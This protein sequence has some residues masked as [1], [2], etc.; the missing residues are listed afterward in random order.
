MRLALGI[1]LA[2]VIFVASG[3]HAQPQG[4]AFSY[5]GRLMLDGVAVDGA[6]NLEFRLYDAASG[7]SQIGGSELRPDWPIDG[8]L[9]STELDFGA[10]AFQGMARW[11]EIRVNGHV[12]EP[13]QQVQAAPYALFALD[14]NAGPEG[15]P[16][17]PGATG[18][19]GPPGPPGPAGPTGPEGPPGSGD[20]SG[21]PGRLVLFTHPQTGGDAPIHV[22]AGELVAEAN[23]VLDDHSRLKAAPGHAL[24]LQ[25]GAD[26]A[27]RIEPG[28][29]GADPNLIAGPGHTM[30]SDTFGATA[31]GGNHNAPTGPYSLI[32]G[33]EYNQASM[34]LATVVGGVSNSSSG[35]ISLVAG[36]IGGEAFGD[37]TA[38]IGGQGNRASGDDAG[39]LGGDHN[40]A[41]GEFSAIVGGEGNQAE[42]SVSGTF[43]ARN[44]WVRGSS[45]AV[46]GGDS[47]QVFDYVQSAFIGGGASHEIHADRGGAIVGGEEHRVWGTNAIALGGQQHWLSGSNSAIL[48][49]SEIEVEASGAASIG[50]ASHRIDFSAEHAVIVGGQ[51]HEVSGASAGVF[52]GHAHKANGEHSV[53][54]GGS[55]GHVSEPNAA[56]IAGHDNQSEGYAGIVL[57]GLNNRVGGGAAAVVGGAS[58]FA[59]GERAI[60]LGGQSNEANG[61][62]SI[63]FGLFSRADAAYSVA[64][65]YSAHTP[66]H[67]SGSFIWADSQSDP[68][69]V[70]QANQF[71]IRASGGIWLG[72]SSS[73]HVAPDE[74]LSTS[75]GAALTSGGVWSNASDRNAKTD[76]EPVDS[77]QVLAGVLALPITTWRYRAEAED[78]RHLGPMAQDFHAAFGLGGSQRSI[79]TV[80][81]DGVALAA[82]QGLHALIEEQRQA[83]LQ[84]QH[85]NDSLRQRLQRVEQV[86]DRR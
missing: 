42:G 17:P 36:G 75:T 38:V 4:S 25:V 74:F 23:L 45:S 37:R 69:S 67:A 26:V 68:I 56:V 39:V 82:I 79:A 47:N 16:G 58:N 63:A 8:G 1:V 15:P 28:A 6:A 41:I 59:N 73:P 81:A 80:D 35:Y 62:D 19:S 48:G 5:Q 14:G 55:G 27:L 33:G 2:A 3:I 49:G 11:L 54:I 53:I 52:A 20:L 70:E 77:G 22:V 24:E 30:T 51:S 44:A 85:E 76:F 66:W 12:L 29:L 34:P 61:E 10:V 86:L 84:L 60:V 32:A 65:G 78:V 7:G 64:G 46:V 71:V 40:H 9:F 43:A 31:I 83:L 57:A 21:T 72:T 50:G 13:R 18:T